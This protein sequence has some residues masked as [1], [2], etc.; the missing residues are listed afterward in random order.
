MEDLEIETWVPDILSEVQCPN[1]NCGGRAEEV[2]ENIIWCAKCQKHYPPPPSI[3]V[4]LKELMAIT[5]AQD[6]SRI[7]PQLAE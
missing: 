4:G 5:Q 2:A 7:P 3:A 1:P 6:C